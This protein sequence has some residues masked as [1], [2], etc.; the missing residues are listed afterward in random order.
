[1][2]EQIEMLEDIAV[3]LRTN[4]ELKALEILLN[5]EYTQKYKLSKKEI[6]DLIKEIVIERALKLKWEHY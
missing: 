4:N 1:M 2:N 3:Q 5:Y 6:N